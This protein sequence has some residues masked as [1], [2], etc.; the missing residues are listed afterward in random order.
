MME[1]EPGQYLKQEDFKA[2]IFIVTNIM[3]YF[4]RGITQKDTTG[5]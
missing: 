5:V 2:E 4:R 3:D 1:L